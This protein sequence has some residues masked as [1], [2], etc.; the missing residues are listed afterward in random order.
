MIEDSP[1]SNTNLIIVT[2]GQDLDP[3][4]I[5]AWIVEP[6]EQRPVGKVIEPNLIDNKQEEFYIGPFRILTDSVE[7]GT[8]V[9]ISANDKKV[10][11]RVRP[12]QDH[13]DTVL[14]QVKEIWIE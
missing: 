4:K 5:I 12:F 1:E 8:Q 10:V 9:W 11:G 14:K 2:T 3:D 13:C 6:S 7:D